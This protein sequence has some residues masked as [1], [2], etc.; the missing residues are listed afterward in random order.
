MCKN[1]PAE[2]KEHPNH[3]H[4][5]YLGKKFQAWAVPTRDSF[6]EAKAKQLNCVLR[7]EQIAILQTSVTDNGSS[8]ASILNKL[9]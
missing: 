3:H 4:P 7:G 8:L 6:V 5:P 9:C 2:E 1:W